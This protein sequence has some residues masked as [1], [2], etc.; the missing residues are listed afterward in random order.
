MI[1]N[2]VSSNL[3]MPNQHR[4]VN[5]NCMEQIYLALEELLIYSLLDRDKMVIDEEVEVE[6]VEVIVDVEMTGVMTEHIQEVMTRN[7]VDL[8]L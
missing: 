3:Q 4:I 6:G 7:F 2:L 8:T 5:Q 1:K